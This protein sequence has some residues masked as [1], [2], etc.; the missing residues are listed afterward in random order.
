MT[1]N[2]YV[3]SPQSVCVHYKLFKR[4][5]VPGNESVGVRRKPP[6]VSNPAVITQSLH[7]LKVYVA[8]T[9]DAL[10][11]C[12][13]LLPESDP[14]SLCVVFGPWVNLLSLWKASKRF[15]C[16]RFLYS[17]PGIRRKRE[18][19]LTLT[20]L[21][22]HKWARRTIVYPSHCELLYGNFWFFTLGSRLKNNLWVQETEKGSRPKRP[23]SLADRQ[24][25]PGPPFALRAE[26]EGHNE[27]SSLW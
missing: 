8:A 10:E 23:R 21:T 2:F 14:S 13:N 17:A 1:F 15:H 6:E 20:P 19:N 24:T 3:L 26:G 16:S 11:V 22:S 9:C 5:A 18:S 12:H 4:D 7:K 25:S 27:G